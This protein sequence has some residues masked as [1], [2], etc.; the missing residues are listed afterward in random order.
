MKLKIKIM[1]SLVLKAKAS[2]YALV[3]TGIPTNALTNGISLGSY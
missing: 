1:A 2:S 3:G